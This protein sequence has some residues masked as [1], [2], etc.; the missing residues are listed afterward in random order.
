MSLVTLTSEGAAVDCRFYFL[1]PSADILIEKPTTAYLFTLADTAL[2]DSITAL[3]ARRSFDDL[4]PYKQG[5]VNR[6]TSRPFIDFTD[7]S[8]PSGVDFFWAIVRDDGYQTGWSD[9]SANPGTPLMSGN[10][11]GYEVNP[12]TG[13]PFGYWMSWTS[14]PINLT[15]FAAIAEPTSGLLLLLGSAMLLIR[16]PRS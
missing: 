10:N 7:E 1:D 3:I 11:V 15:P 8:Y 12:T 6:W 2:A 14:D 13:E 4:T 9:P 16:R 5:A